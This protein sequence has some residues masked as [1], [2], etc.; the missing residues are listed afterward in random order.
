ME[1][2]KYD[3]CHFTFEL[4]PSKVALADVT[5]N[6]FENM[7]LSISCSVDPRNFRVLLD[8]GIDFQAVNEEYQFKTHYTNLV[9]VFSNLRGEEES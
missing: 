2:K 7:M 1:K 6:S 8:S 9:A 3:Y 5:I 4:G